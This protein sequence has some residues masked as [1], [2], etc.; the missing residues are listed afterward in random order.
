MAKFCRWKANTVLHNYTVT[1]TPPTVTQIIADHTIVADYDKIPAEYMAAVKTMM[2]AFPGE[3]HSLAYRTGMELLEGIDA[4]YACNVATGE[5]P[6]S[7]Y[8][9]V[10]NSGAGEADWY[11]WYAWDSHIDSGHNYDTIKNLISS[12]NSHSHPIHALGF[13]WCWDTT[14][15]N[16]P[17]A[18]K[19]PVYSCGWA[20][21][22]V[23]GP[24]GNLAWGLDADDYAITGNRVCMDT[25]LAATQDYIDYC[26]AQGF[27]TKIIFTTS[28]ADGPTGEN[29]YQRYLKH[30]RIRDYVAADST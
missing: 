6:T 11:T 27:V 4:D 2:V 19:D 14:W 3:S 5:A 30:Q 8:V 24:D 17:T 12:Y 18:T 10:N 15:T 29:G 20:G 26:T 23:D 16:N 28:P 7:D 1:P 21:S 25:Y 13:G 9:R 22:S